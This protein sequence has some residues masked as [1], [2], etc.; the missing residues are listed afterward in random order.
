AALNATR[1]GKSAVD[2]DDFEL[3]RDRILMGSKREELINEHE[4][5]MTA[6]HE[7]GHALIAW[8]S[9]EID[10]VHKVTIV[11]RGRALGVTQLLPE[12]ERLSIGERRLYAMLAFMLGGRGAE[13]LVFDEY[14][15]G[16]EDDLRRAT[17]LARRMVAHWGMSEKIGPVSFRQVEEHPFLGREIHEHRQ[18]SEDTARLIDEEIQRLLGE[19]Q[20]RA[21][22][23]LSQHRDK[24]EN[25]AEGL[26]KDEI[27]DRTEMTEII[28]PPAER[29]DKPMLP[30]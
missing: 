26:L 18:F 5:R 22:D 3:A 15:A 7:A 23:I 8:L 21:N 27:L 28:G 10:L 29:S 6:Y 1:D 12:E 30:V 20:I 25:L 4:R 19:A 9:P 16:A 2:K 17:D 24:L 14:T 13:K 11:P